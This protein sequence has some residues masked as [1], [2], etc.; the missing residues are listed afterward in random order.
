MIS[1]KDAIKL[2]TF[3]YPNQKEDILSFLYYLN[4]KYGYFYISVIGIS[5]SI[6]GCPISASFSINCKTESGFYISPEI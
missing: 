2:V 1:P 3:M 4:L 6:V 5:R